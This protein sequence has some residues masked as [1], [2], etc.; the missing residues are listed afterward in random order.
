MDDRRLSESSEDSM[1]IRDDARPKGTGLSKVTTNYDNIKPKP[2]Q[3]YVDK[4]KHDVPRYGGTGRA[5]QEKVV[6]VKVAPTSTGRVPPPGSVVQPPRSRPWLRR[7]ADA[8]L[9]MPNVL[10]ILFL[11]ACL[12]VLLGFAL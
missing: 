6:P 12:L 11:I 2:Y 4:P 7:V 1:I 10:F 8:P 3:R 5:V 9:G